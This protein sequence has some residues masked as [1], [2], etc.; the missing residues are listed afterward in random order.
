MNAE[1]LGIRGPSA[2]VARQ[3][4]MIHAADA[5]YGIADAGGHARSQQRRQN[6]VGV[7]ADPEFAL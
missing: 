4:K 3:Q 6:D 7:V 1:A 5:G 2:P